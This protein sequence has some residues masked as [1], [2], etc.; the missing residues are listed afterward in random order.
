P[1]TGAG[2]NATGSSPAITASAS[3]QSATLF[4]IG[5]MLSRAYESGNPPS[6]GT[7]YWLG[8]HPTMPQSAAGMRVEPPVS[9]PM[10]ISDMPSATATAPPEDEPPGMRLRSAGLP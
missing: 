3:A 10:V 8:F 2:C 6:V 4:A 7:R 9:E 5:P 1:A